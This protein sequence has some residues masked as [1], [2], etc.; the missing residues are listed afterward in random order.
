MWATLMRALQGRRPVAT[1]ENA[2][3]IILT[4]IGDHCDPVTENRKFVSCD[5]AD[6]L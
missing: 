2:F 1:H 6:Y 5:I 3:E 4:N